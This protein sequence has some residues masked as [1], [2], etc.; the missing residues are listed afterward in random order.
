MESL[1]IILG[2]TYLNDFLITV[3]NYGI[4]LRFTNLEI[5]KLLSYTSFNVNILNLLFEI[6][7][8]IYL[9]LHMK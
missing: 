7:D 9:N 2:Q 1:N 6:N 5:I 3:E 8:L 4:F